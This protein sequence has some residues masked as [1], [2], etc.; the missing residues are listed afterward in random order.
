MADDGHPPPELTEEQIAELKQAFNE[1]DK[2]G[3]GN[4]TTKELGYAMRAMGMNPT[5][6]ELLDLINEFDTDGSGQIEFPE[7]CNMMSHKIGRYDND[8]DLIRSAFRVMDKK[9]TG[10][11][12]SAEFR[13]LMTNIGDKISHEEFDMLIGEADRD[14]DGYLDYEE[15]VQLMTSK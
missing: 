8:E 2:D 4:I 15:F 1:F 14:G 9:G 12:T 13:F 3:S 5:E 11:I 10:T 7:F 6:Q